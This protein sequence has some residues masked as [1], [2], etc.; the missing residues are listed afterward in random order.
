MTSDADPILALRCPKCDHDE[1]R[2]SVISETVLS[3][4]CENCSHFWSTIIS[5]L[6]ESIRKCI[7]SSLER[8]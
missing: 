3:V 4:K 8:S 2:L 5:A 6:P 1:A 7:P